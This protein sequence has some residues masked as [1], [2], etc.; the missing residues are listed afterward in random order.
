[1]A[2]MLGGFWSKVLR[3]L[4]DISFGEKKKKHIRKIDK[5]TSAHQNREFGHLSFE[6]CWQVNGLNQNFKK[7]MGGGMIFSK[8]MEKMCFEKHPRNAPAPKV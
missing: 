6:S 1:M 3:C 4:G 8:K 2:K 5:H 7:N